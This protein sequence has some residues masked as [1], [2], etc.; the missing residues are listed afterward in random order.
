[1]HSIAE[2]IKQL[3]KNK[4][5]TQKELGRKVGVTSVTI[6]KWEL[7]I[8]IPKSKS[9]IELCKVFNV[10]LQWLMRGVG[11]SINFGI[12]PVK[13]NEEI[14]KVPYF[15][16]IQASAG[17]GC[18][19]LFEK[20]DYELIMPEFFFQNVSKNLVCL[21]VTGDSME[22]EFKDGSILSIDIKDKKIKDGHCYVVNHNGL[23]R[24]KCLEKIPNGVVLKSYNPMYKDVV[25]TDSEIFCVVGRVVVQLSFY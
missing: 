15:D 23:L 11:K 14:V 19:V 24:L 3:R 12:S 8:A 6:S 1:M 18:E 20:A 5:L 17:N 2:R 7:D 13:S 25:V 4:G 22:P 21:K 9:A 10:D 16:D